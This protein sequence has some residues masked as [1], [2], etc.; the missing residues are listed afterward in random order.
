MIPR[1]SDSTLRAIQAFEFYAAN[2]WPIHRRFVS[3]ALSRR[4]VRCTASENMVGL[5]GDLCEHCVNVGTGESDSDRSKEVFRDSRGDNRRQ[6]LSEL[7]CGHEGSGNR[8]DALVLFS[9]GKDSTYMCRRIQEAH[10]HLRMLA[11]TIDNGFMSSIAQEN[12]DDLVGRLGLDH[13]WVRPAKAFYK[14]LF[15]HGITHLGPEGGYGT[16]DFSDGEFMLD[17]ARQIAFE[18]EIPLILCGYSKYQV[19][20]GLRVFDCESPEA[21][22]TARRNSVAGLLLADI[23][24]TEDDRARWWQGVDPNGPRRAARLIFPLYAWD[25]E[26]EQI[27]ARVQEWGLL[28]KRNSSVAATNHRLIPL[29]GV[30]DVHRLGYSSYEIEFCRMIREGKASREVWLPTFELLE[31]AAKTGMFVR[32]IVDDSLAELGLTLD[33]VGIKFRSWRHW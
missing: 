26:E 9:G 2:V 27:K 15:S 22:E 5:R 24:D 33:D 7:L 14:R 21:T 1:M 18:K 29:I 4:C 32:Q 23:F 31:F 13:I 30:V 8:Y 3:R 20:N 28:S 19:Q 12:V 6:K 25:L 11:Y 17:T 16:V 10:P